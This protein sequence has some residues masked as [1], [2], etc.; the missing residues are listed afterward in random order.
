MQY[1][2]FL[3]F[4]TW[5]REPI[6]NIFIKGAQYFQNIPSCKLI[7]T[8]VF[9]LFSKKNIFVH[10]QIDSKLKWHKI[11]Y[12]I[13]EII[14]ANN[15]KQKKSYFFHSKCQHIQVDTCTLRSHGHRG[16]HSDTGTA[17]HIPVHNCHSHTLT[18]H[19][20]WRHIKSEQI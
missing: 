3:R 12:N 2:I 10:L 13:I 20:W 4:Y 15:H 17:G 9:L 8:L 19:I 7:L 5:R 1:Y 6:W 14:I 18:V 16:L 11:Y